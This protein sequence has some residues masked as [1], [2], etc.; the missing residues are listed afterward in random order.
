MG[1][2]RLW[3]PYSGIRPISSRRPCLSSPSSGK[4]RRMATNAVP[5]ALPLP[6]AGLVEEASLFL[7]FDGTLVELVE[8]PEAVCF[9]GALRSLR[10]AIGSELPSR[11]ALVRGPSTAPTCAV[12]GTRE[13]P[14][15]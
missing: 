9:G 11:V 1:A 14:L 4:E 15:H 6:P 7:D 10:C 2:E 5:F 3:P 12:R 8:R 13:P